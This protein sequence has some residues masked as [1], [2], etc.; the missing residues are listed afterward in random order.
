MRSFLTVL[1]FGMLAAL[2]GAPVASAQGASIN[3]V[4]L[5]YYGY[6]DVR[7]DRVQFQLKLRGAGDAVT[8]TT[9]EPNTFG[10]PSALFLTANVAGKVSGDAITFRKTY[11]GTGGQTHSVDYAGVFDATR[12]CIAGTWRIGDATGPFKVCTDAGLVS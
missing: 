9:I 12:R 6:N 5:G 4:W 3:R 2:A 11:D 1:A 8:G 10:S 7:A